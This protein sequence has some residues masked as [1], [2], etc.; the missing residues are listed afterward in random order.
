MATIQK[1]GIPGKQVYSYDTVTQEARLEVTG[2]SGG[3]VSSGMTSTAAAPTYVEAATSAL[4]G[5]LAGNLRVT[6]GTL[7][8]GEDATNDLLK[9]SGGAV[10]STVMAT[11]V[12]TNTTS[13]AVAIPVGSK[14]IYGS[15]T[16]T[17]AVT[18]TQAIYGGITSGVTA[19][20]GILLGTLT[21]SGT[22]TA[23]AALPVIT[24]NFLWYIVVTTNTTG[25]SASGV[26]TAMY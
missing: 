14:T 17:G 23:V 3:S 21:L 20:T 19:T 1:I 6:L 11:G 8:Y 16:G 24:A 10:R 26:V 7:F 22:T 2:A 4:S 18:Q 13:T 25:T 15:V 9:V 12:I 5:D